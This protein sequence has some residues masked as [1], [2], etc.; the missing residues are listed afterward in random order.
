M[1]LCATALGLS[2]GDH[3]TIVD[4]LVVM[5]RLD[6]ARMVDRALIEGRV[7]SAQSDLI[8]I[9]TRA[10]GPRSRCGEVG[11]RLT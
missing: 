2:I 5:R 10:P 7:S 4:W 11:H 6:E 1:S 8:S 9:K 3:C